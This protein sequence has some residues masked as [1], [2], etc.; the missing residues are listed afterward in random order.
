LYKSPPTDVPKDLEDPEDIEGYKAAPTVLDVLQD[1]MVMEY[2][3]DFIGHPN[4][5]EKLR[6]FVSK[7]VVKDFPDKA[8]NLLETFETIL[9]LEPPF[10]FPTVTEA[11]APLPP[12]K[13][14]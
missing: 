9:T 5:I 1:W 8:K 13:R 10:P 2:G 6:E 4:L 12:K 11:P 14:N 3:S 7:D